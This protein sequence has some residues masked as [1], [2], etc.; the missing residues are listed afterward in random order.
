[1]LNMF[2]QFQTLKTMKTMIKRNF[3]LFL[4]AGFGL[5]ACTGGTNNQESSDEQSEEMTTE[6]TADETAEAVMM[7]VNTE[8]S[9]VAWEGTMMGMYSHEGI[10]KVKEGQLEV[11]GDE[12]VGGSFV[13]DL[14]TITPTDENYN[15]EEGKSKDKLVQH[16][17][18][19]DFFKVEEFPTASFTVTSYDAEN[20]ALIGDLTIRGK[21]NQETIE[22]VSI[23][24]STGNATGTLTFDRT[25]YDVSFQHPAQEMVLSDEIE[26]EI[27]LS[28]EAA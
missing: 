15:P 1:M 16:L 22:N 4:I 2:N 28:M 20:N 14:T 19:D 25:K 10:V 11:A 23:D 5:A 18:S 8:N 12:V 9:Q 21:T 24:P 17:S 13:V 6:T 26:L 3:I 7:T 27:D